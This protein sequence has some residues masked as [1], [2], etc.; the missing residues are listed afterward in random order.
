MRLNDYTDAAAD[1]DKSIQLM[2][3]D[4]PSRIGRGITSLWLGQP[5]AAIDDLSFAIDTST[6][7]DRSTAWAYRARGLARARLGLSTDAVSDY[8]AYLSLSPDASDRAQVEGW[9]ADLSTP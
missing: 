7:P 8:T 4:R 1:F 2:P 6:S 5:Q 9:I 3:T